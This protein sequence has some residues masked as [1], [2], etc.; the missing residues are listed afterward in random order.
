MVDAHIKIE[1]VAAMRAAF[2]RLPKAANDALKTRSGNIAFDLAQLIRNSA[3]GSSRQSAAVAKTVKARR[4]RTPVVEA[5]G[6][7]RA[8]RQRRVS[9]GQAP[10]KAYHLLFGANFG[11]SQLRQFRPHRG[12]GS[13]D[14]W[15]FS[16]VE[17]NTERIDSEW[18]EAVDDVAKE[19]GRG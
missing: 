16:T 9:S 3:V 5:G 11:A 6:N 18:G 19:W 13:D 17:D 12:A 2:R 7:Q 14:Y 8:T 4:D 15:F 1:G 10:T